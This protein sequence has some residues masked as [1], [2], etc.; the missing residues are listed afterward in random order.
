MYAGFKED[1]QHLGLDFAH[2][3]YL[4]VNI[5]QFVKADLRAT[6]CAL[7]LRRKSSRCYHRGEL[8]P[9]RE[10]T[11]YGTG[12]G[13]V[14]GRGGVSGEN[15]VGRVADCLLR[16]QHSSGHVNEADIANKECPVCS[17]D[18]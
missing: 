11:V 17:S 12:Q 15:R 9:P 10:K 8:R 16:R 1:D 4:H 3:R 18:T 13:G 6:W 5:R 7:S 2:R 14:R